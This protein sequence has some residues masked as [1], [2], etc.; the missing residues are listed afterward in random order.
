MQ[1]KKLK[2]DREH[3]MKKR[4]RFR[5]YNRG[6]VLAFPPNPQEW[7]PEGDLA[8]FID[9]VVGTLDLSAIYANYDNARGGQPPY[10]PMLMVSLLV[11]SYCVGTVSSRKIETATYNLVPL[12]VLCCDEH[13]DHDTIAEFRRRNLQELSGL[14]VQIL[15]LCQKAGL[16]KLGHISIDGTKVKANASKHKAMSYGR[17]EKKAK[18]LQ[19]QVES[20]LK[21]AEATDIDEDTL[22]GKGNRGDELPLELRFKQSRLSKIQEAK[23]ALEQEARHEAEKKKAEYESKKKAWQDKQGR[24]G[25]SPKPPSDKPDPKKQR[26][27]TDPESRIMPSQGRSNFI[28]GYNCQAAV[29]DKAQIIVANNVTQDSNDKK[30]LQPVLDKVKSNMAGQLPKA[31]SADSGYFS[32]DNCSHLESQHVDG[33]I[34][35][36]KQKHG[37]TV[38]PAPRGRI[39]KT[40][41]IK[42]RMSRKLRTKRGRCTYSKRKH[43]VEPVF[44]QIKQF[45]GFRQFSM[46]G[47]VKCQGE[48]DLVCL[49]H[50]ILKLFRSGWVPATG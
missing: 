8:Y 45:R 29:D 11:Y 17:M 48:W 30:Q 32:E 34:S 47:Y 12:R 24:K 10:H 40:A 18:E 1:L 39:P 42:E 35:T 46:R 38:A 50:N 49:T 22:Y 3:A 41:T 21:K 15:R 36:G 19:Q 14:F 23:Q 6:Q 2:P 7:L 43:I 37:E 9:D 4:T 28:Q 27:F 16:V 5:Q 33:Y 31:L 13:P 44:G 25:K 20:L 26:N